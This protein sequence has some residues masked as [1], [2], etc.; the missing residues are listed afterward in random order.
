MTFETSILSELSEDHGTAFAW[1][2]DE[3]A[4]QFP[5]LMPKTDG[6]KARELLDGNN[7]LP[8]EILKLIHDQTPTDQEPA[9]TI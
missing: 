5:A 7:G 3:Q 8:L 2:F 1:R 4:T 9:P 6:D